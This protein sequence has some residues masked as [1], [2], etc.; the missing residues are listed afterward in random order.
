MSEVYLTFENP[1]PSGTFSFPGNAASITHRASQKTIRIS[2][3][4]VQGVTRLNTFSGYNFY[5]K[6]KVI[7][8]EDPSVRKHFGFWVT[9]PNSDR[10]GY[11]FCHLDNAW[12]ASHWYAD[13]VERLPSPTSLGSDD[14]SLDPDGKTVP[15]TSLGSEYILE[16]SMR[17]LLRYGEGPAFAREFVFKANGV[18]VARAYDTGTPYKEF[19]PGFFTYG[20][21]I[22]VVDLFCSTEIPWDPLVGTPSDT[23]RSVDTN[24][25][26]GTSFGHY[27]SNCKGSSTIT[28]V[29]TEKTNTVLPNR[30]IDLVQKESLGI[31]RT[32]H[33]DPNGMF[34]FINLDLKHNFCL[35]ARDPYKNF[36]TIIYDV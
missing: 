18:I 8:A 34:K 21:S 24:L 36:A 9:Q 28:G 30:R 13:T 14:G 19:C 6:A 20:S 33:T 35:V 3:T 2:S 16:L 4:M 31:V 7:F 11:R 27:S 23:I 26:L 22:D 5:I 32:T 12:N 10:I 25:F 1:P 29:L 17:S 15:S